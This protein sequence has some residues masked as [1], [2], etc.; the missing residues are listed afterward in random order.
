M[1]AAYQKNK[2]VTMVAVVMRAVVFR[3]F[4]SV[5][6]CETACGGAIALGLV[7]EQGK[8]KKV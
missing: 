8:V 2:Q 6:G 1:N 3:I 4:W 5:L 7:L